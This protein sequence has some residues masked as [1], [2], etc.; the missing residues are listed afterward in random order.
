MNDTLILEDPQ[1]LSLFVKCGK[2]Y[3]SVEHCICCKFASTN[4]SNN[5][6]QCSQRRY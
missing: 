5:K 3:V 1:D 6:M 4:Q 2:K